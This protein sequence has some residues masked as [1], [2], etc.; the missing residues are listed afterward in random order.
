M[1]VLMWL[2][3]VAAAF[4]VASV[5]AL[6]SYGRFAR[7]A[8]G[9]QSQSLPVA[10]E[11]T[12]L[13]RLIAPL[14]AAH[15]GESGLACVFD[16]RDAFAQ[17]L[18]SVRLAGRSLDLLYYIWRD[19]M[20]GRL[21]ARELLAAADRGVRVR[22]L[23]DD[24]NAQGLDPSFRALNGHDGIEVRLFN[25]VRNRRTALRRGLDM[26]LGLVR[27][28]RRMHAKLWLA[29][30]R[31]GITGGRN[32]GNE[33]FDASR[34]M[35]RNNCDADLLFVG[36][37]VAEAAALF[38]RYWN[39]PQALPI[40]AFWRDYESGLERFRR[41][42]EASV[43]RRETRDWLARISAT[44]DDAA[45]AR[46]AC[47]PES[48]SWTGSARLIADPPEKAAGRGHV[49]W[50]AAELI[51]VMASA[52]NSLLLVTPYFVPGQ[53]GV[54]QLVAAAER[55]V[56]VSV[57]T[58]ALATT[59]HVIVHGAYRRYRRPLLAAG[60][61]LY[62]YA[63]PV[64]GARP[65]PMLHSKGFVADEKVAFIGSFNFD[66]RSAF[67]NIEAGVVF[68]A[69]DLVAQTAE[70]F[71]RL[72]APENAHALDIDGKRLH[73]TRGC[74]ELSTRVFHEPKAPALR[75]GASWLIGHLPIHSH[76]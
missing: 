30:G 27:L 33:Y 51:S 24:V 11:A 67:L 47:A 7:Q 26:L 74:G 46:A 17:R 57:V 64:E 20:T 43:A 5:L 42:V 14:E 40:A 41:R 76:L 21:L 49:D 75:R 37:L 25:P 36:P 59:N 61:R 10:P 55:G 34:A 58:N 62:E 71:R 69:P 66:L 60:V 8:R 45:T 44:S 38:D 12:A 1:T 32:I 28:N 35:Q 31:L 3:A 54:A 73:W 22:L 15:P 39:S 23:L 19:D 72:A 4:A 18:Q 53:E 2:L 9:A 56:K 68:D 63:P 52:R 6:Y 50:M 48:L 70:E 65:G 16:N 13:D 29:D